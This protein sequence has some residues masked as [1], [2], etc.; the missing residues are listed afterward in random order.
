VQFVRRLRPGSGRWYSR[1][2]NPDITASGYE[3]IKAALAAS[4]SPLTNEILFSSTTY[5]NATY[6]KARLRKYLVALELVQVRGFDQNIVAEV[7][8]H[9]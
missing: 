1:V 9:L 6:T 3:T 8:T 7:L 2:G 5:R 4:A